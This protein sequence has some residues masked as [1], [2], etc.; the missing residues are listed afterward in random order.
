M[1][2]SRPTKALSQAPVQFV[3]CKISCGDLPGFDT[4]YAVGFQDVMRKSGY[5]HY[6]KVELNDVQVSHVG[7]LQLNQQKRNKH[8]YISN[9]YMSGVAVSGGDLFVYT[10]DYK[11]FADFLNQITHAHKLFS[12]NV[13]IDTVKSLGIR[14]L[15]FIHPLNGETLEQYLTSYMLSPKF[16]HLGDMAKPVSG[17]FQHIYKTDLNSI[18][19]LRSSSGRGL[20][21]FSDDL[22]P[23]VE[24]MVSRCGDNSVMEPTDEVCAV[25]DT[26]HVIEFRSLVN[27]EEF[28]MFDLIDKMHKY[29]SKIFFECV[30]DYALEKW[31]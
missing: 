30:T 19:F 7:G 26:D 16:D 18:V 9:D 29:T 13:K 2:K 28:D 11:T 22:F 23:M 8:H 17:G 24:P 6:A 20:R 21:R 25:I 1:A 15:D 3:L 4:D 12:N 10:R 31:K 5:P 27:I 14:Y